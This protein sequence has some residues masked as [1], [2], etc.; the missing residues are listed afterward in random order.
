[1]A[2]LVRLAAALAAL[3]LFAYGA[4]VS[5]DT[6]EANHNTICSIADLVTIGGG[7]DGVKGGGDHAQ[8]ELDFL[9]SIRDAQCEFIAAHPATERQI[10]AAIAALTRRTQ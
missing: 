8:A 9:T 4:K 1:M 6:V 5:H 3:A 7:H 10:D 2:W